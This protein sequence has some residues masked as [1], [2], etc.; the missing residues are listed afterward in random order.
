[1]R[2][3]ELCMGFIDRL[4]IKHI[5]RDTRSSLYHAAIL[6][7]SRHRK[8]ILSGNDKQNLSSRSNSYSRA[9][10]R[11]YERLRTWTSGVGANLQVIGEAQS[12]PLR[13]GSVTPSTAG[14]RMRSTSEK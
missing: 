6:S 2:Y 5:V 3:Y 11:A 12:S 1:M 7:E 8:R 14:F 9:Y 13:A 10:R 4:F